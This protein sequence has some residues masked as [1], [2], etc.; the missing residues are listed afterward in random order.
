VLLH[1]DLAYVICL[2]SFVYSCVHVSLS[3]MA[4]ALK[5]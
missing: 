1:C 4:Q 2:A 5:K 3:S